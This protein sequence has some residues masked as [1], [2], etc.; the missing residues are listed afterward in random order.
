M[1]W[2]GK[3]SPGHIVRARNESSGVRMGLRRCGQC[4]MVSAADFYHARA[5][6]LSSRR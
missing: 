3:G 4:K 5:H 6:L 1:R 2:P